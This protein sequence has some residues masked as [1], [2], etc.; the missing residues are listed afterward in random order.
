MI[1]L[2]STA[3]RNAKGLA[4]AACLLLSWAAL[5]APIKLNSLTSCGSTY[6]NITILTFNASHVYFSHQAGVTS[7]KL[8]FLEPKLQA[9]FNY[10]PAAATQ[11]EEQ[12]AASEALFQEAVISNLVAAAEQSA[13]AARRAASTSEDSLADPLT[14]NSLIGKRAPAIKGEKWIGEKPALEGRPMLVA[15]WAPWSIPCRKYLPELDALQKK[16]T[17]KLSVVGVTA[18]TEEEVAALGETKV[19]FASALDP[20]GVFEAAAGVTSVPSVML[21]DAK[22]VVRYQG[23]PAAINEKQIER[24]LAKADK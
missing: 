9:R 21:V 17:G 18:A 22:G 14:G 6:S 7:L 20:K 16:F 24:L 19:E 4:V 8:K 12:Q 3:P 10:D 15:F 2:L 5:G 1:L 11:A 13:L 23:H